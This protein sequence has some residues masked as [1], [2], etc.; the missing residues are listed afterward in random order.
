MILFAYFVW[1]TSKKDYLTVKKT[2]NL[3]LKHLGISCRECRKNGWLSH[4]FI[5]VENG[6]MYLRRILLG[7]S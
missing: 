1:Y 2:Q 6:K 5:Q 4:F 3:S 7:T